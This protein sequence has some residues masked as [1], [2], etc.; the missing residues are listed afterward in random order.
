MSRPSEG[1]SSSDYGPVGADQ[2]DFTFSDAAVSFQQHYANLLG[3]EA[4]SR[5]V[6]DYLRDNTLG[7]DTQIGMAT[8]SPL[9]TTY[10]MPS[11]PPFTVNLHVAEEHD[12]QV[13]GQ[14]D[15]IFWKAY[16]GAQGTTAYL[17][18][19][20]SNLYG[21]DPAA[22]QSSADAHF[23]AVTSITDTMTDNFAHIGALMTDHFKGAT[24]EEFRDWYEI[25][26]DVVDAVVTWSTYAQVGAEGTAKVASEG[27][28]AMVKAMKD[29]DASAEESS[30]AWAGDPFSFPW[31][32]GTAE[33]SLDEVTGLVEKVAGYAELIPGVGDAVAKVEDYGGKIKQAAS[34]FGLDKTRTYKTA[35]RAQD[36]FDTISSILRDTSTDATNA[37]DA[38]DKHLG[39][40]ATAF[41]SR[42]NLVLPTTKPDL[43]YT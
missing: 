20:V 31:F 7:N 18:G 2:S 12:G 37:W 22:V 15:A 10:H 8:Q 14:L 33:K 32:P 1:G 23:T 9:Q 16:G 13:Q 30:K 40:Q 24:A 6:L 19:L 41:L 3:I 38:L 28:R 26:D 21:A 36:L 34:L 27:K 4:V 35:L 25:V 39:Q 5:A 43:S 17:K 29:V 42:D 11:N